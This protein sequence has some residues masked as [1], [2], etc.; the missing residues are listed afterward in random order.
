MSHI[1][2]VVLNGLAELEYDREKPLPDYQMV[3]LD[4]MDTRMDAGIRIGEESIVNPDRSQRAQFIAANLLHAIRNNDEPLAAALCSYLAVRL[5]E[6]KQVRIEE[7]EHE[8]S[9]ELV[10]DEEYRRQVAVPLFPLH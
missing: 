1:M 4:R 2:A 8:V 5:P 3:Y 10:F 9:I 7:D 6:L